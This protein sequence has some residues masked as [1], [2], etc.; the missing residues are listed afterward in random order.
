MPKG[1]DPINLPRNHKRVGNRAQRRQV[2]NRIAQKRAVWVSGELMMVSPGDE[3]RF[4]SGIDEPVRWIDLGE[5][6]APLLR[7][8]AK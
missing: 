1:K 2:I 5:P 6:R 3:G 8:D 4:L 7:N